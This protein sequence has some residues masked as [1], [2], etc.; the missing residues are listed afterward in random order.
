MAVNATD[1]PAMVDTKVGRI[2]VAVAGEYA[3]SCKK[4][5]RWSM[6]NSFIVA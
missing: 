6:E 5:D 1:V 3:R 2:M 4:R